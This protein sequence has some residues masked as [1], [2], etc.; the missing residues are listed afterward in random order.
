MEGGTYFS[1]MV[2]GIN[3]K[4]LMA[5]IDRILEKIPEREVP[6]WDQVPDA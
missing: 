3:K 4:R 6:D 2:K 1:N 5:E